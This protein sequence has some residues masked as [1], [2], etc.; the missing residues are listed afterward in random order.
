MEERITAN[1][2]SENL[3][4]SRANTPAASEKALLDEILAIPIE[5]V[6][7]DEFRRV[8]AERR[9]FDEAPEVRRADVAWYRPLM[10]PIGT[11]SKQPRRRDSIVLT[12][13]EERVIF[14]Q[15][16][17]ARFRI[18][19]MQDRVKAKR[20][21]PR[22]REELL[23]WYRIA[24]HLRHRIAEANLA[25]VLAMSKRIRLGDM[26]FSDLI[27]EGNMALMRSIDK[28][29][30]GRGFKFSTYACRA[31]LKGFS[32]HGSKHLRYR[33]RFG[34]SYDPEFERSNYPED[35]RREELRDSADEVKQ[36]VL[37][38][39]ADLTEVEREVIH[40]RFRIGPGEAAG[41]RHERPRTLAQV[42]KMIGLT[43]ER[44]RQIQNKALGKL[45]LAVE[46][47]SLPSAE[48]STFRRSWRESVG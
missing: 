32:R 19:R 24:Q 20:P 36:F 22:Q 27:S 21:G 46:E 42:G 29:D 30:V 17:Y 10:D 9:I 1:N 44:V 13:A 5:Y 41:L 35:R 3:P 14:L 38:N 39:Q 16:N 28:F 43:K 18:R 33:Q 25:L 2:G 6:E 45:R 26:D 23:L 4:S 15:Y 7:S 12:A 37:Q 11:T 8:G 40:H 47:S 31:I 34:A 48:R